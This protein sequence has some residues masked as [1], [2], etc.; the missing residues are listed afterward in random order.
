[1]SAVGGLAARAA[2]F[3]VQAGY[4]PGSRASYQRVWDQFGEYCAESGVRHP[5]REAAARFCT[6]AGAD[7]VEQWQVFC[8]RAVGCLFD[9]A[10]TGRFALRAGRGRIPVPEVYAAQ[11][12]GCGLA[13]ATV[14]GKTGMLR[15]F[16]AFLADLGVREVAAL[17]VLDVSDYVRSLA[18]MAA[19]SRA[20]QLYFLREYLRFAV[21]GAPARR[22][23]CPG[24]HVPGDRHRQGRGSAF[25]LPAGRGR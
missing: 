4:S 3:M 8:R 20:G 11:L 24:F 16:L 18:P 19:F 21:R 2:A 12:A 10:E 7:G 25:G 14:R 6:T 1:M 5:D 17:S 13:E 22:R 23:S 9:V 15:R